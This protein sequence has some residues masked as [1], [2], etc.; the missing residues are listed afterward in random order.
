MGIFSRFSEIINANLHAMLERAEDPEKL[1][2]LMIHE[3][4]DTLTEMKS[5][6]VDVIA[7]GERLGKTLRLWQ[8]KAEDWQEKAGL[9]MAK[10]REDLAREALEQKIFFEK[11]AADLAVRQ[12]EIA[13]VVRRFQT[14]IERLEEKLSFV[15]EK[16][17]TLREAHRNARLQ[18]HTEVLMGNDKDADL[19]RKFETYMS[20]FDAAE[21]A[22]RKKR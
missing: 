10:D 18:H 2:R 8:G 17:K 9:A 22:R 6:A 14:D 12:R 4:E 21:G 5:S 7:E 16:E 3:M 1:S 15:Q 19:Y 13:E 11:K 20:H